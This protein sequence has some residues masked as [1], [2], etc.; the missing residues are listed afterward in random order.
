MAILEALGFEFGFR[1]EDL[2][3][4]GGKGIIEAAENR[5]RKNDVLVFA[6]RDGTV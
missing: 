2:R 4:G 6:L 5:K 1:F 3:L